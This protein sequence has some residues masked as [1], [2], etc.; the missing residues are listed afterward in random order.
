MV[1]RKVGNNIEKILENFMDNVKD[2]D[3]VKVVNDYD[4]IQDILKQKNKIIYV[5]VMV[6][7]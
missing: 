2:F 6:R 5:K 7:I 4:G 1:Y 3:Y